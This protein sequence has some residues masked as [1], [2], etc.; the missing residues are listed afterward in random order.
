MGVSGDLS[1]LQWYWIQVRKRAF[2]REVSKMQGQ[3]VSAGSQKILKSIP[4]IFGLVVM[5]AGFI[6][7]FSSDYGLVIMVLGI[8]IWIIGFVINLY[9]ALHIKEDT[10]EDIKRKKKKDAI[11]E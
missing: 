2:N 11:Y 5:V 3:T 8:V 6:L 10:K 4:R 7:L 9:D 1:E